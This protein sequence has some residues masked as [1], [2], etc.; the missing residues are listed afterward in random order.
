[1]GALIVVALAILGYGLYQKS[2]NPHFK[3]FNLE[4]VQTAAPPNRTPDSAQGL[5][6]SPT[7]VAPFG[8]INLNMD[9]STRIVSS[10]LSGNRL[11][12]QLRRAGG[13][14]AVA[15]VDLTR[16]TVLGVVTVAP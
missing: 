1:M 5:A 15:V 14:D 4:G 12:L 8:D 9:R 7:P 10:Q 13:S 11:L 6:Q 3:F 2:K 16:G